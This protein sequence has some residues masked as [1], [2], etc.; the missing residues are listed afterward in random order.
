ML[1]RVLH[2]RNGLVHPMTRDRLLALLK[3]VETNGH[4]DLGRTTC[5]SCCADAYWRNPLKHDGDCELKVAIDWL[6]KMPPGEL[7]G[8]RELP[9]FSGLDW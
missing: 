7:T 3:A 2:R 4:G 6:E 8:W 1:L 5:P 9:G